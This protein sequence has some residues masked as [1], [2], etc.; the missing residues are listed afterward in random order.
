[1]L[2]I[3]LQARKDISPLVYFIIHDRLNIYRLCGSFIS[4]PGMGI[5][6]KGQIPFVI[7]F[8]RVNKIAQMSKRE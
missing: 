6:Q 3:N 2:L 7:L 1:M 5:E 8:S 4:E